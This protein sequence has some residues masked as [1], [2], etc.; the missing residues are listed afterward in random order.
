[1]LIRVLYYDNTYDMVKPWL[2]KK[3][4]EHNYIQ[5]FYRRTG[6]VYIGR[7][8][9]RGMGGYYDGAERRHKENLWPYEEVYL[10]FALL[11]S[12]QRRI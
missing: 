1:M 7:D 2:L 4:I 3:L 12:I 6:W 9:I 8:S 5:A 11:G 10:Y